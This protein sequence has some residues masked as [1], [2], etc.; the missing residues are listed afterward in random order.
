[1]AISEGS[2]AFVVT[3]ACGTSRYII[4]PSTPGKPSR[5]RVRMR[6]GYRGSWA[7]SMSP[8]SA[9]A[10]ASALASSPPLAAKARILHGAPSRHSRLRRQPQMAVGGF[11]AAGYR[12]TLGR[13][14]RT[15]ARPVSVRNSGILSGCYS[16]RNAVARRRGQSIDR[17]RSPGDDNAPNRHHCDD[18][19][20]HASAR[21]LA[22]RRLSAGLRTSPPWHTTCTRP[23]A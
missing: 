18:R 19:M 16:T 14:R 20:A 17:I 21:V 15:A 22:K 3:G 4:S 7:G 13:A 5:Y 23:W 1:M 6:P 9:A 10:A 12:S 8:P 2:T 11:A